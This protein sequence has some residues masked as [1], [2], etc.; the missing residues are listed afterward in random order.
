M[1]LQAQVSPGKLTSAH[2]DLE[3]LS[4]CT[5][6]HE[7]GEA[8]TNRKCLDCHTEINILMEAGRGFHSG[9]DVKDAKCIDCH[10]EHFGRNF[11]IVRFD[12]DSFDHNDAG[13]AL[14]GAHKK[15]KCADCHNPE[16]I[17]DEELKKRDGTFLGLEQNCL[18][19][20]SDYHKDQL[21]DDCQSCHNFDK[22]SPATGFTHDKAKFQLTGA[23]LQVD[24]AKCHKVEGAED[25]KFQHFT[26]L[27]FANC[28]DCHTDPHNGKF[29]QNCEKCHSTGSFK[30]IKN[31]ERFDHSA[32]RFPLL[33]KHINVNCNKCH[34]DNLASKPKFE[35]CV[36]CHEDYHKGRF[37]IAGEVQDC[38]D[39]HK[40]DGF[41]PSFFPI[42]KHQKSSFP[43]IGSHLAVPCFMCHK[44][45]DG[46]NFTY[47]SLKCIECHENPHG[48]TISNQYF[49]DTAC[50]NCHNSERW[51]NISFEHDNTNFPLLGKH[52]NALC[53]D[54]HIK[55]SGA[56]KTHIFAGL[57]KNCQSCHTDKHFGQFV[58][59]GI[60]D[61]SRCHAFDN[62]K[63]VNF[64]HDN[65]L[66]KLDG[67]HEKVPCD[68][69]HKTTDREGNNFILYK[70][71]EIRCENCHSS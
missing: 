26:G 11:E 44:T 30:Q 63:A 25:S 2:S 27:N 54:C 67:A 38:A 7:L 66:F 41:S 48:N 57:D 42:E 28:V 32:T 22:F 49:G 5:K 40:V 71:E 12:T 37:T 33:G 3:G 69:C 43:L 45:D 1:L 53:A 35:R 18:S 60:T 58:Q 8:V 29:G 55:S 51:S 46:W 70:I 59:N 4:N 34:G 50:E 15:Q 23:H 61:C 56:S 13:Y 24:C 31:M 20:H 17:A 52:K 10:G 68:Q 16:N 39:C 19:C 64:N 47:T 65:T 9:S 21:T 62:W 36:D 6:C 14:L